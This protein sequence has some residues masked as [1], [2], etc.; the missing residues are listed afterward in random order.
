MLAYTIKIMLEEENLNFSDFDSTSSD[1]TVSHSVW[2]LWFFTEERKE[3]FS[4]QWRLWAVCCHDS[5]A[6]VCSAQGGGGWFLGG[7]WAFEPGIMR[8]DPSQCCSSK[9]LRFSAE[10]EKCAAVPLSQALLYLLLL[11]QPS[12]MWHDFAL[13]EVERHLQ[14]DQDGELEWYE[15]PPADP[16]TLLQLLQEQTSTWERT[17]TFWWHKPFHVWLHVCGSFK[18]WN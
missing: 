16:E 17:N 6:E 13:W 2:S 7:V 14:G 18:S 10:A 12:E 8:T 11:H 5:V 4:L 15:L 1:W 3:T 9:V